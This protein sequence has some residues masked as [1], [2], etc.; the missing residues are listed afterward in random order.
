MDLDRDAWLSEGL[1]QYA[2]VAYFERT[3]GGFEPNLLAIRGR[4]AFEDLVTQQFGFLNLREHLVELPYLLALWEGFDEAL[5]KPA[6]DV[7]YEN[8]TATRLYDKG[9]LV[10]RALAARV[11]EDAF[12]RTLRRAVEEYADDPFTPTDLQ[13]LLEEETGVSLEEWFDVWVTGDGAVDYSVRILSRNRVAETYETVV[14]LTRDGGTPQDVEVEATLIS[15]ATLR[16]TWDG[17]AET[18]MTFRTPSYVA[19]VTIDPDH[20]LPDGDRIDNNA[21]VKLVGAVQTAAL[22]LDAYVLAPDTSTGGLSLSRLDRFRATISQEGAS[23]LVRRGRSE[24]LTG[25]AGLTEEGLN[26]AVAYAYTTFARPDVGSPGTYWEPDMTLSIAG[27][28][29]ASENSPLYVLRLAAVDLPSIT[30]G[31]IATFTL[32]LASTGATR[33]SVSAFDEIRLFPGVYAQGSGFLGFSLNRLPGR[34]RFTF[35]ELRASTLP[36]ADNKLFGSLS[37]ELPIDGGLPYNLFNVAMIDRQRLR[38]FVAAGIGWTTPGQFGTTSPGVEAGI[39]QTFDLS[40]LGGLLSLSAR[41]GVV[42]QIRG[43]I[44]PIVYV[45]V[46]L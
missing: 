15:G 11:G 45:N 22:P 36:A 21:P 23:L 16:Q 12:D 14:R 25:A 27:Y 33:L 24:L 18:E 17:V 5:V 44:K 3:H 7:E 10:A 28:R 37:L 40:T 6:I 39:E 43:E 4:G 30:R 9:Y 29:F 8:E 13:R 31:S 2:S 42:T 46:S 20:R 26:G 1:S 35:S 41:I 32:D 34:L 38:L 19:R